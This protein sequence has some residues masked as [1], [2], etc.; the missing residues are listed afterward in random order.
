MDANL[1]LRPLF[2]R[3]GGIVIGRL[4]ATNRLLLRAVELLCQSFL[5]LCAVRPHK[6]CFHSRESVDQFMYS[7]SDQEALVDLRLVGGTVGIHAEAFHQG[8]E[9]ACRPVETQ[10]GQAV[11]M[12]KACLV[13]VHQPYW[14]EGKAYPLVALALPVD[15][16]EAYLPAGMASGAC[17]VRGL[18]AP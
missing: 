4:L 2:E 3:W 15:R 6:G 7:S 10:L 14:A 18:R 1:T 8:E 5:S 11:G 12:G 9:K 16:P 13:V 17:L